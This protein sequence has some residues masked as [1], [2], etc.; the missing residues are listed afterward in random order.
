M[1]NFK[2]MGNGDNF[3]GTSPTIKVMGIG[4]AGNNAVRRL[5]EKGL[6]SEVSLIAI[7]TEGQTLK[8]LPSDIMR[9]QIGPGITGGFGAG[10]DPEI[11]R[12]AAEESI[13][14]V[15]D[16]AKDS[17]LIFFMLGLGGGTGTGSTPIIAKAIRENFPNALMCGVMT[18]PFSYE[19][20]RKR[21]LAMESFNEIKNYMDVYI[22]IENDNILSLDEEN[23]FNASDAFLMV[24]KVLL[25]AIRGILD[26]ISKTGLINVDF[27]DVRNVMKNAGP[28]L[29]GVA[30]AEGPERAKKVAQRVLESKLIERPIDFAKNI[31]VNV[32]SS[33]DSAKMAEVKQINEYIKNAIGVD[34][35]LKSGIYFDE[36]L[37]DK[38]KVVVIATGF[39]ADISY[40]IKDSGT[41][42][43]VF[44]EIPAIRRREA[45][46]VNDILSDE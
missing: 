20:K 26:L 7:N 33:K 34:A 43:D 13:D 27:A 31:L 42:T 23:N 4:G 44:E 19:G 38:I 32:F 45:Y 2:D 5:Y 11:G 21:D 36:D 46:K 18:I 35:N 8:K 1:A 41:I 29:F 25:D 30:M 14:I 16:A 39:D 40:D 9:L 22:K 24:D 15:L 12:R 37:G 17:D 28:A 6:N 10:G 3:V